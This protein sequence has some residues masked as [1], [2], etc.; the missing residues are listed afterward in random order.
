[1][2][3]GDRPDEPKG[4]EITAPEVYLH[5]RELIKRA[6]LFALTSGVWGGGLAL[7]SSRGQGDP[8]KP[9]PPRPKTAPLQIV[10]RAE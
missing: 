2:P 4:P 10:R 1:M 6:G 8:P 5:R 9:R 7:L 3:T